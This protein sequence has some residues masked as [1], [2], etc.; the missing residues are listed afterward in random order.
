VVRGAAFVSRKNVAISNFE[1]NAD[2]GALLEALASID[3][4]S[5]APETFCEIAD[6]F[7]GLLDLP[8]KL[9]SVEFDSV[10]TSGAGV[11][12]VRLNPS[13]CLLGFLAALRA[14]NLN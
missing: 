13:D 10:L 6:R 1:I 3:R 4:D 2:C 9:V 11:L 14:R 8:E 7:F 12:T 5:L